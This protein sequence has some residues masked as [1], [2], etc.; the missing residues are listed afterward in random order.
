MASLW[1]PGASRAE[2]IALTSADAG[3][4]GVPDAVRRAIERDPC[5]VAGLIKEAEVNARG[6]RGEYG[7]ND[8]SVHHMH[9]K[10]VR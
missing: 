2:A 8:T 4:K 9:T 6:V 3:D 10:S 5:L 7:G 1:L